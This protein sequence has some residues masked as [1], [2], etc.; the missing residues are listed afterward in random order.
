M[1]LALLINGIRQARIRDVLRTYPLQM[2]R[3]RA[4]S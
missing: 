3:I 1:F 2:N 4:K